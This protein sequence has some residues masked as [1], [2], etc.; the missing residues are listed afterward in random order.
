ML[1][2]F[3]K[4]FPL[5]ILTFMFW[6]CRINICLAQDYK[7]EG[8]VLDEQNK[9]LGF[10]NILLLQKNDST[11][12]K[13]KSASENGTYSIENITKG[14]Y[15]L[16]Y[17]FIGYKTL[18]KEVNVSSDLV[19]ENAV[20]EETPEKLDDVTVTGRKNKPRIK[21]LVDKIVFEV[22]DTPL[23]ENNIF[24]VLKRTPR[25]VA[26]N[27]QLTIANSSAVQI[28]ING[29]KVNLP[30]A[31]IIN[32]LI[33]TDAGAV[34]AIEVI[35]N[36]S[37]KYDAEGGAILNIITGKNIA[38]GYSGSVFTNYRAAVF[39]KILYST[40]HFLK[41][42]KL[43]LS[44]NYSVNDIKSF[45][46]QNEDVGFI[47]DGEIVSNWDFDA[48][49]I[50]NFQRHT[51]SLF[52]DYELNDKNA[53][54]A[55]LVTSFLASYNQD[56][57]TNTDIRDS[58][59][60]PE[61]SITTFNNIDADNTNLSLNV[62]YVKELND[63]G[64]KFMLNGN[65]VYYQ[66]E[67]I[68]NLDTDFF[69]NNGI[70]TGDNDFFTDTDKRI[71]IYGAQT[72][73]YFPFEE[74]SEFETGAKIAHINSLSNIIQPGFDTS[75]PGEDPTEN[76]VF[77]YDET[78]A[79]AYATYTKNWDKWAI[80]GGLR[81]EYTKTDGISEALGKVNNNE[82][83]EFFPTFY[84]Q[85]KPNDMH[86][87][88]I[89]YGRRIRRP[90]YDAV[91]PF[92][93]FIGNNSFVQGDPLL[94]PSFRDLITLSYTIDNA[95]T[96]EVYYR[97]NANALQ[98]LTFQDNNSNFIQYIHTNIDRELSYG[99]DFLVQKSVTS[100]WDIMSEN[101]YFYSAERFRNVEN[102]NSLVDNGLWTLFLS[103]N[104]FFT[105]SAKHGLTAELYARYVSDV[106]MGN[107]NQDDYSYINIAVT[108]KLFKKRATL[109]LGLDDIFNDSNIRTNRFFENQSSTR[110]VKFENR[111]F[112]VGFR[113]TFGNK[114]LNNNKEEKQTEEQERLISK[115]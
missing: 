15:L 16:K 60:L 29:R 85:Y 71:Q 9:P 43:Q 35:T 100:F 24:E 28:L 42:D 103:V 51:S 31:D 62:D 79:A 112:R 104:N 110:L 36:P 102:N 73:L 1:H 48:R 32:F 6:L 54:S 27:E 18:F 80:K 83:V 45:T 2:K 57:F 49:R 63:K 20:L 90:R 105:I 13:G 77:D 40:S 25:V 5:S 91:N 10:V 52:F 58:N 39:P 55:S 37:A 53:I 92:R 65:Y 93:T 34:E 109:T 14:I 96:F 38:P 78:I 22:A 7:I 12:V 84:L 87:I 68:Q 107:A 59:N 113:Y 111:L 8:K 33:G 99:F 82:Y 89:N 101:S 61:S 94:L 3:G 64:A 75:Q 30:Q 11:V 56:Y 81:A 76:D 4:I 70:K 72:D 106:V 114:S 47:E 108:K 86:N 69:D 50:T 98:H 66:D 26:I 46:S 88:N 97:F 17:S 95:Y 74:E 23:V 21:R 44:F 115:N 19:L 67:R 41:T